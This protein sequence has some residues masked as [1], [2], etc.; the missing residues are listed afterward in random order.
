MSTIKPIL[1]RIIVEPDAAVTQTLTGIYIPENIQKKPT[2]GAVIACGP[3]RWD[4]GVFIEN[5]IAV[6]DRVMYGEGSG[7]IFSFEDKEYLL[8]RETDIYA[9]I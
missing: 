4:T 7:T 6:G 2:R 1:D 9:I 5:S 8:M 3:G